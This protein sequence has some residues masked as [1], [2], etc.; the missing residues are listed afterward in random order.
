MKNIINSKNNKFNSNIVSIIVV[1]IAIFNYIYLVKIGY[2]KEV[3]ID[4]I[5]N[6]PNIF[7]DYVDNYY[8]QTYAFANGSLYFLEPTANLQNLK[9][10]YSYEERTNAGIFYLYDT[11]YYNGR[12]YSYYTVIPI[13]FI[14]LPLYF[15]TGKFLNLA[16]VNL[17]I[18]MLAILFIGKLYKLVVD[19]YIG[20][21]SRKLYIFCFLAIIFSCNIFLLM[22]GLKYDIPISCGILFI[23]LTL[24]FVLATC[25]NKNIKLKMFFAGIC[26]AFI[27]CSKPTY[28]V[29]YV[30]IAYILLKLLRNNSIN[31]KDIIFLVIPCIVIGIF[32]M[33]Y[34]YVRYDSVFE[35]GAKYNLTEINMIEYMGFSWSKLLRGFKFYLF[36]LPCIDIT[37]FPYIFMNLYSDND[38]HSEILYENRYV[39]MI[40][41]P[42]IVLG[43]ILNLTVGKNHKE[44]KEIITVQRVLYIIFLILVVINT[45]FAGVS[46]TYSLDIKYLLVFSSVILF[47][48]YISVQPN[49]T[50]L[51]FT[52]ILVCIINIAIILPISYSGEG[53]IF[54]NLI[55][56][57]SI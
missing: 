8:R 46:E 34:N 31:I 26:M 45:T 30:L 4:K 6:P 21:I 13:F 1:V 22:R 11:S 18:L 51:K 49:N 48:K 47:L 29:Y 20:K 53:Q 52:I 14:L 41:F 28:I 42:I 37:R 44:L 17:F 19:N 35:F 50:I 7:S 25:N 56:K 16:I 15:I 12:Y 27:V 38:I 23:T 24:Y 43:L 40:I 39:G 33:L 5:T 2:I 9:N 54:L 32:Q 36:K 10:P 55:E 57:I 3:W